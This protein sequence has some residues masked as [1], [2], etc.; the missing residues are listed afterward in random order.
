MQNIDNVWILL[1]LDAWF[2]IEGKRKTNSCTMGMP[3]TPQIL[4]NPRK[5]SGILP[6]YD[7][8]AHFFFMK[9]KV[10]ESVLVLA[11][12]SSQSRPTKKHQNHL[13]NRASE[14]TRKATWFCFATWPFTS[15]TQRAP[16]SCGKTLD[17]I[18]LGSQHCSFHCWKMKVHPW[19]PKKN[20][21]QTKTNRNKT[22]KKNKTPTYKRK[23]NK[24]EKK[25]KT[26]KK[27]HSRVFGL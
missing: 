12:L 23:N 22:S 7:M 6:W 8:R 16:A 5:P 25:P 19:N 20:L 18:T 17:L 24:L 11:L 27:G 15:A 13:K 1:N 2:M 10:S 3:S 9:T 21:A 4:D 26:Q 14:C